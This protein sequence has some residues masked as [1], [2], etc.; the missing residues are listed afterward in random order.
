MF[1]A[2]FVGVLMLA[3]T[4]ANAQP[5]PPDVW[6]THKDASGFE[7]TLPA[8]WLASAD[9]Q[10]GR[11]TLRGDAS[12]AIDV[13]PVFLPGAVDASP[14][15]HARVFVTLA[16]QGCP[17]AD[18]SAPRQVGPAAL[19]MTGQRAGAML[20]AAY[21]WVASPQ[22]IAGYLYCVS[23]PDGL[24]PAN[25][26]RYARIL[27]SLKLSGGALQPAGSAPAVR[28][29]RWIDPVEQAFSLEVP[30]GWQVQG[31]VRRM[32][33]IEVRSGVEMVSPD[34]KIVVR[35]GDLDVPAFEEPAPPTMGVY[36][37]EGSWQPCM[38]GSHCLVLRY[39]PG[40]IFAGWLAEQ[41]TNG[42]CEGFSITG[43]RDR[44]DI[45]AIDQRYSAAVAPYGVVQQTHVGE[46]T[47]ACQRG[48]HA[49][50]GYAYARTIYTG[51]PAAPS[52]VWR[53]VDMLLYAA[54]PDTVATAATVAR[55]GYATLQT[56]P[57]WEAMQ[58]RTREISTEIAAQ[59]RR[60]V[61]AIIA[62]VHASRA[63]AD[64]RIAQKRSLAIRGLEDVVDP[65]T[66]RALQVESGSGYY[67]IDPGG[68]I[69][70]TQSRSQPGVDFRELL[71]VR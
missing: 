3:A 32:T 23:D 14:Q 47:F 61:A 28:F 38:Q 13:W 51:G 37:P 12:A 66:G 65:A 57:Q 42:W 1:S 15:F 6:H 19:R 27:S 45:A 20:I 53:A 17:P 62:D 31:G 52:G 29:L 68:T 39:L 16:R 64:D 41:R 36:F 44:P 60:E 25:E 7:V 71:R 54:P 58:R 8:R 24:P 11:I 50:Q 35:I 21:A 2:D 55:R 34:Q 46:V 18:W 33:A 63:A 5:A 40:A 22:G 48:G 70:G 9:T 26:A 67:W 10:T 43:Q 59:S 69:V 30:D 49:I 4:A 56:N